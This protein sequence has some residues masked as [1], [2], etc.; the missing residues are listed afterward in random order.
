MT[1]SGSARM[2]GVSRQ[3]TNPGLVR[4]ALVVLL[5]G[6]AYFASRPWTACA[7]AL[8]GWNADLIRICTF[9]SGSPAFDAHGPGP[10]WPYPLVAAIYV[11][12][13]L[14]IAT[15]GRVRFEA[16]TRA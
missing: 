5:L 9:G 2:R 7:F 15:K 11:L 3:L 4:L 10:L 12:A 16:A 8:P 14:A 13:V 1:R 6:V